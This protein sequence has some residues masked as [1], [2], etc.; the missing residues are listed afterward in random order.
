MDKKL[1]DFVAADQAA[2]VESRALYLE[3]HDM[4]D[5][6]KWPQGVTDF[7]LQP[8]IPRSHDSFGKQK[9]AFRVVV[10]GE[11]LDWSVNPRS[12]MYG[13][14][15]DRLLEAPVA[16]KINRLGEGL[17]TRYSLLEASE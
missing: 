3:E 4:K 10:D 15:V 6:V 9:M 14:V 7:E 11:E 5:F 16:M 17:K 8:T 13:Q 2:R 1:E 12:P